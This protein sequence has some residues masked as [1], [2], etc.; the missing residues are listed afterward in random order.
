MCNLSHFQELVYSE[1]ADLIWVT[2]TWLASFAENSKILPTAYTIYQ[3]DH[4]I[5]TGSVLLAVKTNLFSSCCKVTDQNSDLE[6]VVL[7]L[8]N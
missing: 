6:V 8:N 1:N 3:K 7:E 4:E 5:H 2:E